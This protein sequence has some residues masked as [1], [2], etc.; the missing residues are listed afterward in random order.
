MKSPFTFEYVTPLIAKAGFRRYTFELVFKCVKY[1][2]KCRSAQ[3]HGKVIVRNMECM[4]CL[5]GLSFD[6]PSSICVL[7]FFDESHSST[8]YTLFFIRNHVLRNLHVEC[9]CIK[10]NLH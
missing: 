3:I 10:K 8:L 5:I 2:L 9:H 1:T 4:E 7:H 6:I